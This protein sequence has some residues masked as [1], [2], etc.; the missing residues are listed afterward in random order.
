MIKLRKKLLGALTLALVGAP[1]IA[2]MS[3]FDTASDVLTLQLVKV[4]NYY[5]SNMKF[6]LPPSPEAWQLQSKGSV[7]NPLEA[8]DAAI[9][10]SGDST[11]TVPVLKID[12]TVFSNT[13]LKLPLGGTWQIVDAGDVLSTS[14]AGYNLSYPIVSTM[15]NK[16][17]SD[18]GGEL[19]YVFDNGQVWKHVADEPCCPLS[20]TT[21]NININNTSKV[22]VYPNPGAGPTTGS[23]RMV[24]EATGLVQSGM[25]TAIPASCTV[26]SGAG[27]CNAAATA[28]AA[29]CTASASVTVPPTVCAYSPGVPSVPLYTSVAGVETCVVRPIIGVSDYPVSPDIGPL[30]VSVTEIKGVVGGKYTVTITGGL[31]PY[32]VTTSVPGVLDYE[33]V[34]QST[35]ANGQTLVVTP[36]NA[37]TAQLLVYDYNRE[38]KTISVE[39]SAPAAVPVVI[40][41]T[42]IDVVEGTFVD[43]YVMSGVPPIK[44]H[45]PQN[46]WVE[47]PAVIENVPSSVRIVMKKSTGGVEMP[48]YFT[49]AAGT[50][51]FITIKIKPSTSPGG[52]GGGGI[53]K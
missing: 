10:N 52:S 46:E 24:V 49:D 43:L 26:F 48:L 12:N 25:S 47:A 9:F 42:S 21:D 28:S 32:F 8:A 19:T 36:K 5:F 51:S 39:S 34:A 17:C 13:K 53:F 44:V 20:V 30:T 18:A 22:Y 41:P 14:T 4:G 11:I 33:L 1:A 27:T 2:Q 29:A 38:V 7:V 40:A 23:F 35:S 50:V 6:K 16:Y 3:A 45:N 31:Q 15:K 37:G